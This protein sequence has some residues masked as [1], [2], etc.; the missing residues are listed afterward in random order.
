MLFVIMMW[1]CRAARQTRGGDTGM[2]GIVAA[3]QL[4]VRPPG[5]K[6][7]DGFL[8]LFASFEFDNVFGFDF[9]GFTG[10]RVPAFAGFAANF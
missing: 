10:L 4:S 5:R 8:K 2:T 3:W 6:K 7:L 1:A 9:D